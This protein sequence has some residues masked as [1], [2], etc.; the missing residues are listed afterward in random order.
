MSLIDHIAWAETKHIDAMLPLM[1][2]LY[3]DDPTAGRRLIADACGQ[4]DAASRARV[5]AVLHEQLS[6]DDEDLIES[7]LDDRAKAVRSIAIELLNSLTTSQRARRLTATL[8][9][10]VASTGK[11]RKSIAVT[12][13]SAPEGE[14]LRDLPPGG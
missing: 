11:L 9:P 2:A 7:A 8:A 13:P 4:L 14:Q 12:F 5:L 10:L 3:A 1:L 6:A